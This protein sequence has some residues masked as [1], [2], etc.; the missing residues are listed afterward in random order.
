MLITSTPRGVGNK[1]YE[2]MT[3]DDFEQIFYRIIVDIFAAVA[4]GLV[5]YDYEGNPITDDAG[6]ERLRLA[7]KDPD[8]WEEEYLVTFIDD[9]L[10]LLTY[11][12]IG[13]CERLHDEDGKPYKI[14]ELPADFSPDRADL[15]R[16]ALGYCKGGDLYLGF[17]QARTKNLSVVWLDEDLDGTLW[18]RALIVMK[19]RDYEFQEAVLWQFMQMPKLR[20]AG[21]DATGIGGRTAERTVTRYG[22]KAL[23]INFSS[24]LVDRRGES[25]PVKSLLARV[26]L[27]RHQDGL[28]HYPVQDR[29]RDDFHRV[30]R[31][32]GGSPDTFTYFAD[33]DETGHA[34]I[35]TAKALSDVVAQELREYAGITDGIRIAPPAESDTRDGRLRPDHSG[36]VA[37][38]R[39]EYAGIGEA[40]Y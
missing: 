2:I 38:A 15:G 7:L 20:L 36:D 12:L 35:F 22:S 23:A 28:D 32:R 1:F 31:K 6:V 19:A 3:S 39:S 16:M 25:H 21:I 37:A 17:D 24:R 29:I 27:E 5:L 30:K 4:Q 18:Q 11:E 13:R 26:I 33:N 9:V 8:A 14:L 40:G 34:D 10:N